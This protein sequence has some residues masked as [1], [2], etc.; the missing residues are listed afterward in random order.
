MKKRS[1]FYSTNFSGSCFDIFHKKV[2][3]EIIE[4]GETNKSKGFHHNLSV[5]ER[6]AIAELQDNHNIVIRSSDKG[7]NVVVMRKEEYFKEAH[8]QLQD[9]I[10]YRNLSH[11][12]VHD[13]RLKMRRLFQQVVAL[14]VL[15]EEEINS[16][17]PEHPVVP[18]FHFL[19]KIHKNPERPPGRPIISGIGSLF[20]SLSEWVDSIL[21]PLVINLSSYLRDSGHLLSILNN[22]KWKSGYKWVV[23]D[24]ALLYSSIP[25]SLGIVAIKFF[26]DRDI[27]FSVEFKLFLCE[28]VE[29][30]LK[31]IFLCLMVPI[32]Y[33]HVAPRWGQNLPLVC[34]FVCWMVGAQ[35]P[36]WRRESILQ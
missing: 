14:N 4:L 17:I 27:N 23:I 1:D 35:L 16:L 36:I 19:P 8:R 20:E 31:H 32:I 30:L 5:R 21:Q 6:K 3:Q 26:L 12:P 11:N 10:T 15:T 24:A 29:F 28:V 34:K 25:H 18:I 2:E 33:K 13:F 7:G 22:I 9:G